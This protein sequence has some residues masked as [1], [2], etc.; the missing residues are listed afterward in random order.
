MV[1]KLTLTVEK[2]IVQRAK[3]YASQTGRSL[4]K[5]IEGYLESMV[6]IRDPG[7]EEFSPKIKKLRGIVKLPK[8]FDY[9]KET[10]KAIRQKFK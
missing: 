5:M 7:N 2:E 6:N 4:S 9:K 10:D 1:V 3:K 8:N